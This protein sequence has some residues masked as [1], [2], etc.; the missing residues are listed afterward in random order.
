MKILLL[1]LLPFSCLAMDHSERS[2][3]FRND[4]NYVKGAY[5]YQYESQRYSHLDYIRQEYQPDEYTIE[6]HI[7]DYK[8]YFDDYTDEE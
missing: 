6:D 8:D 5:G 1:L 4:N 7:D 3:F 2:S